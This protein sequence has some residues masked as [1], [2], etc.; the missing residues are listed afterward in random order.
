MDNALLCLYN[1]LSRRLLPMAVTNGDIS[2]ERLKT[3]MLSILQR[4]AG[5]NRDFEEVYQ[6]RKRKILIGA[7]F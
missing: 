2:I 7:G 1:I 6:C 4:N 3:E 5:K